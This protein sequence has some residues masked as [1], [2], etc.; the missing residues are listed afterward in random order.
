MLWARRETSWHSLA[1]PAVSRRPRASLHP[2]PGARQP[3]RASP[4]LPGSL[5]LWTLTLAG[6][7]LPG[8]VYLVLIFLVHQV[9][10]CWKLGTGT[11]LAWCPCSGTSAPGARTARLTG[12]CTTS[13]PPPEMTGR[14]G[15][16]GRR[17]AFTGVR[18]L[19]RCLSRPCRRLGTVEGT[20]AL[21]DGPAHVEIASIARPV[22]GPN[23]LFFKGIRTAVNFGD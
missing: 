3:P 21:V 19:P 12:L 10:F 1:P 18:R 13:L 9:H 15:F 2:A 5:W 22:K 17:N 14:P 4:P 7:R 20:Q 16:L 8:P 6:D 23:R 11:G